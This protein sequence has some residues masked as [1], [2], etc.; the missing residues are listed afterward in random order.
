VT[1]GHVG[2][3]TS[4]RPLVSFSAVRA[5]DAGDATTFRCKIFWAKLIR[6][7]QSWLDL[8]EIWAKLGKIWAKLRRN[9]VLN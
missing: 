6:F 1:K 2:L 5:G 8:A 9:S 4:I 3:V 7:R